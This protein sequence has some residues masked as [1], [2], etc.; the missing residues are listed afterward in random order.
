MTFLARLYIYWQRRS[1]KQVPSAAQPYEKQQSGFTLL[2]LI[3]TLI[4]VSVLGAMAYPMTMNQ[5]GRARVA[6]ARNGLGAINR[7]QQV[8][9]FEFGQFAQSMQ[10]LYVEF[11]LGRYED[12]KFITKYYV[13][14]V[15]GTP[16]PNEVHHQA[17]PIKGANYNTRM[18]V[19]AVFH[20]PTFFST[21]ICEASQPSG[22]PIITNPDTCNNGRF[23]Q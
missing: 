4:I 1:G 14:S 8:Y 20:Q 10:D 2:E 7:A 13:Y 17:I 18:V 21:V 22:T 12:G 16:N 3:I 9:L 23:V 6:E 19:S 5:I 15:E 11:A